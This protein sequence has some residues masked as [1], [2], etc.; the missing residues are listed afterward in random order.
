M[1]MNRKSALIYIVLSL[2]FVSISHS[3]DTLMLDDAIRLGLENSYS[4]QIAQNNSSIARNNNTIGNA[5][6]LPNINIDANQSNAYQDRYQRDA[7]GTYS[8]TSMFPSY[9]LTSAIQLNWTVF[10]GLA[11][12]IRKE[13]LKLFQ[14]QSELYL[15]MEV[16]NTI[17]DIVY[18]YYNIALNRKLFDSFEE[19]LSLSRQRLM[20]AKEKSL[21]G[22][23][24]ELQELQA[25]VDY[26]ADSAQFV[27]Q[28]NRLINLKADLNR[29]L[30]REPNAQFEVCPRIPLPN[31]IEVTEI[32]KKVEENNPAMLDARLQTRVGE[33]EYDEA[34]S[35]RYP[36]VNV[37]GAYN[38]AR[39]GTPDAQQQ[40]YI[41]NG[42]SFGI[43]ASVS[44]FN[45]F[46]A[47]RRIENAR[48]IAENQQLNREELELRLKNAAF[49]LVNELNQAIELVKVEEK[50]VV[51]AQRNAEAAWERFQLGAISD[52]E[53]RE[54][55]NKLLD[56]QTRLISA[57]MSAQAAEIEINTLTGDMAGFLGQN[58]DAILME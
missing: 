52:L 39:T 37:S 2:F 28:R 45:G 22:V 41:T 35:A 11:M 47:T 9:N 33:L 49:K 7:D 42:P 44:L 12:F 56:A 4:I 34:R 55:Q 16:E 48:I 27:S 14:E 20:V 29:L 15:R 19:R 43:G 3:Q 24:Y 26:R 40:L 18:T 23:G 6:Y 1:R 31:H 17:A 13:K 36:T 58:H 25:E 38:F 10:D 57:Q 51:L 30:R 21:I 5:G 54:S 46:N 53:L 32:Y 50:S 8:S